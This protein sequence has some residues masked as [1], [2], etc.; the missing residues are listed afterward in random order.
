MKKV[1]KD[2]KGQFSQGWL[3]WLIV[4]IA[5]L[6][7][8]LFFFTDAFGEISDTLGFAPD[9][10]AKAAVVCSGYADSENL[11]LSYCQFRELTINEKEQ[12]V[13]CDFVHVEA[14]K[15]LED[16]AGYIRKGTCTQDYCAEILQ[17]KEGY[18]GKEW[19]NGVQCEEIPS[20]TSP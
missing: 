16:G 11:A 4:G 8:V 3:M 18:D 14:E 2:K 13:N 20:A 19:V 17:K 12:W 6:V 5:A 7:L 10:L 15:I 1:M 9:D